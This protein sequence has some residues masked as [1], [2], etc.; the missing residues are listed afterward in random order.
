MNRQITSFIYSLPKEKQMWGELFLLIS[1]K[2]IN[3]KNNNDMLLEI[4]NTKTSDG[5]VTTKYILN[6][7]TEED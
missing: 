5:K 2:L 6:I 1:M 7:N 3:P 4:I